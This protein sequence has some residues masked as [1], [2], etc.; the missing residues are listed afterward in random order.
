MMNEDIIVAIDN[1]DMKWSNHNYIADIIAQKRES[2]VAIK[3]I[4]AQSI[5]SKVTSSL[6]L[7]V[8]NCINISRMPFRTETYP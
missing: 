8:F 5:L 7:E 1:V 6:I 4:S 3:L 2:P